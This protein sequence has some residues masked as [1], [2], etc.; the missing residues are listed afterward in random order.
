MA[1]PLYLFIVQYRSAGKG[2]LE[3]SLYLDKTIGRFCNFFMH[4]TDRIRF[5]ARL[6]RRLL[7]LNCQATTASDPAVGAQPAASTNRARRSRRILTWTMTPQCFCLK[8]LY[9]LQSDLLENLPPLRS[10][11]RHHAE[12]AKA[13][14]E[15]TSPHCR[16]IASCSTTEGF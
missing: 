16:R 8:P 14:W 10:R 12:C 15:A 5:R 1:F 11:S 3:T 6:G 7:K 9:I 13:I 2:C 4:A